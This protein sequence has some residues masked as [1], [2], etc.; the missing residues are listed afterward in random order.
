MRRLSDDEVEQAVGNLLRGGVV[1]AAAVTIAGAV[2]YLTRHGHDVVD[3]TTFR[4]PVDGLNSVGGIIGHALA[5]ETTAIIQ[6]GLLL[7]I[8]T[9][10]ARVALSLIGFIRQSD[11]TYVALTAVVLA[12]LTFSLAGGRF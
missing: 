11:R 3:Y 2:A 12:I 1:V 4:G 7:L 8:A 6:L 5:G 9:P 10:V